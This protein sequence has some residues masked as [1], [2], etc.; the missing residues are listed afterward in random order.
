VLGQALAVFDSL[1][2]RILECDAKIE[3]LLAP[4]GRHEVEL[5]G[6]DKRRQKNTPQFDARA[7][8]ARWAGWAGLDLTRINGLSVATVMSILSEI[9]P[10]LSRF[11]SVKHFCSWR[12]LCPVPRSVAAR[13]CLQA[14]DPPPTG[15]GR[16]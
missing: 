11:A 1:A 3:A 12:R 16:H 7:A 9:G 8:L 5:S 13:R 14:L 6:P 15:P 4:L 2:Q 10:D